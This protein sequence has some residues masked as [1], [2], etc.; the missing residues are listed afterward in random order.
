MT[1]VLTIDGPSGAGKGT[2]CQLVADALGWHILDS[3]SLYRLTALASTLDNVSSDDETALADI[4]R[5]LDVKFEPRDQRLHILLR[6]EDVSEAIRTEENGMK[7]S[8][9]AAI[10]PVRDAL[11]DRQRAFAQAPGL[12]A[13]GRDMG[14]TVF[15]DAPLKVF[16]TASCEERAQRRYNQLKEKGIHANLAA[17]VTDLKVRD[18]QDANR[19]VSPLKPADDAIMLDTT[20]MSIEEVTSKVLDLAKQAFG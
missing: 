13:D 17:L 5:N 11:L 8:K 10:T 14:T 9:I 2:I 3:G 7:A 15:P 1:P 16:M 18:E 4:A 19:P 20:E 6:G 12:V